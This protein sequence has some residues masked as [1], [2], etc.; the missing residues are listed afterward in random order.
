MKDIMPLS[1][2]KS[3][4]LAY[5]KAENIMVRDVITI[6]ADDFVASAK[7]KMLRLGVGGLPV[8]ENEKLVG[9]ITHRDAVLTG[10]SAAGLKVRDIMTRDVL[11]VGRRTRL[12]KIVSLMKETGYQRLP[13][14]EDGR[15]LGI[16]TQSSIINALAL[17]IAEDV[18]P[19]L[20]KAKRWRK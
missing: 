2:R 4:G 9:M 3:H 13:V 11:T 20:R 14:A 17:A 1:R 19:R 6:D 15:L 18:Q 8:V 16:V 12:K 5:A 7:L 10:E